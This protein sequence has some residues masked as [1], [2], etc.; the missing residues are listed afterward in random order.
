VRID[1]SG[2]V[3]DTFA[4]M[5]MARDI[6]DAIIS[7]PRL[8]SRTIAFTL[9]TLPFYYR[10]LNAIPFQSFARRPATQSHIYYKCRSMVCVGDSQPASDA[11]DSLR[12]G[13]WQFQR[14]NELSP[15][16]ASHVRSLPRYQQLISAATSTISQRVGHS[17]RHYGNWLFTPLPSRAS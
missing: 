13:F 10:S 8:F 1:F 16:V 4:A 5:M 15:L 2:A 9:N 3:F 6:C 7:L 14:H 12:I 17:L 11:G